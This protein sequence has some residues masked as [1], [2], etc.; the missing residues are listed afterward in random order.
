MQVYKS[1]IL[2]FLPVVMFLLN[3]VVFASEAETVNSTG[4]IESESIEIASETISEAFDES[5]VDS[6]LKNCIVISYD[7]N[8]GTNA[9]FPEVPV[10]AGYT[11][12]D[13][14]VDENGNTIYG[15][16]QDELGYSFKF[17]DEKGQ[18]LYQSNQN[19]VAA[20]RTKGTG[21]ISLYLNYPDAGNQTGTYK[22]AYLY[23][24]FV[25][26]DTHLEYAF[27]VPYLSKT[28]DL[29]IPVG[30]YEKCYVTASEGITLPSDYFFP[31]TCYVQTMKNSHLDFFASA[32]Q[33]SPEIDFLVNGIDAH[34]A[35]M[36]LGEADPM[37]PT[38]PTVASDTSP[39]AG[40]ALD[41]LL[42][43]NDESEHTAINITTIFI[44]AILAFLGIII[45]LSCVYGMYM[46]RGRRKEKKAAHNA[47]DSE[48]R[49]PEWTSD[50][51]KNVS[52]PIGVTH[53]L[54]METFCKNHS[55]GLTA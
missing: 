37:L 1:K 24:H 20:A 33:L 26:K 53:R 35:T 42:S 23:F 4:I 47:G 52:M 28:A 3:G 10:I 38:T 30:L 49:T 39:T 14:P 43:S 32:I 29:R 51:Y 50:K 16:G 6:D 54:S 55:S 34:D 22:G 7:S 5:E 21:H 44:I 45:V 41:K 12:D 19:E 46:Y 25:S 36:A 27:Q 2:A 15:W 9:Y 48:V 8:I 11:S 18:V 13:I 31:T 40:G 17:F